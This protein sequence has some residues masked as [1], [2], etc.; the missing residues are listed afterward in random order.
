MTDN[1]PKPSLNEDE[2]MRLLSE[3][4]SYKDGTLSE[5]K[6]SLNS[7]ERPEVDLSDLLPPE[8]IEDEQTQA[9]AQAQMEAL[10]SNP[11]KELSHAITIFYDWDEGHRNVIGFA[12]SGIGESFD[13]VVQ[14]LRHTLGHLMP[15]NDEDAQ[16]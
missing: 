9:E 8:E 4:G 14:E 11:V 3:T 16:G 13:D 2:L 5:R 15:P 6:I 1:K 10:V 12:H 7:N